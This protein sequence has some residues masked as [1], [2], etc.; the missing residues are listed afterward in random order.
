MKKNRNYKNKQKQETGA[1]H[2]TDN[3]LNVNGLKLPPSKDTG[4]DWLDRNTRLHW[5]SV[6]KDHTAN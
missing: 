5:H 2:K 4:Y 6:Y 3:Y 1:M